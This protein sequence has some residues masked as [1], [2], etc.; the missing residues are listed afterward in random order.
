[1]ST[2]SAVDRAGRHSGLAIALMGILRSA[3]KLVAF[4]I[5]MLL[6]VLEPIV[7]FTFA[8]LALLGILMTLFFMLAGPP[9]FPAWT[10]LGVSVGFAV[11]LVPYHALIRLLSR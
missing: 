1:M 6:V 11:V 10:M 8:S 4:P 9:R 7:T 3:C 5:L 2:Y